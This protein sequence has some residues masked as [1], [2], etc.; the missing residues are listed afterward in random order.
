M[1]EHR[2]ILEPYTG[3]KSR[4]TCPQ[5]QKKNQFARY[6]DIE[7]KEPLAD[8]V[9]RCNRE[10]NC[11]YHFTPKQY[12]EEQKR[13]NPNYQPPY[14]LADNRHFRPPEKPKPKPVVPIPRELM[15]R[16]CKAY[17]SNHLATYVVNTLGNELGNHVLNLYHVGTSKHWPGATVF[18]QIDISG[19]VRA[20]K[21][22]LYDPATGHRI[23]EPY[24]HITWLHKLVSIPG[25]VLNQC[26]FGEHLLKK[27]P[28]KPAA[29]VESEKT[30]LL[31]AAWQPRF[32]W[33]AAGN[34]NNLTRERCQPLKGKTVYL[35]PDAGAF[36][37]W[38]SKAAQMSDLATFIVSDLVE[39]YATPAQIAAGYDLADYLNTRPPEQSQ[40]EEPRPITIDDLPEDARAKLELLYPYF[41]IEYIKRIEPPPG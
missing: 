16:T 23:K 22:M 37:K 29:I 9:G 12:F 17:N 32:N 14:K 20:G 6:L 18:W 25:Y 27:Y 10:L 34:L 35:Y 11:G 13:I 33:L 40:P 3:V 2:Y 28:T 15:Q 7:T 39:H 4:Q 21:I 24:S 8:H 38:Q 31:A 1:S 5:C 26:L 30:A 19:R 41:D 36:D